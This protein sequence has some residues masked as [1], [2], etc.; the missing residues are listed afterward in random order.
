MKS[1]VEPLEDNKVKVVVD[2]EES[3]LEPALEAAWKEI[4]NEV[5]IPGFRP[6]KAP[7]KLLEKQIDTSYARSE[8]LRTALPEEYTKAVIFHDVDVV[9]PPEL[10]VTAGEEEGDITFSAIVEVRPVITVAGY[11]GLRVELPNPEVSDSDLQEEIDRLRGQYGELEDVERAAG[12]GDYVTVD[13][14]GT[15]DGEALDGLDVE[16]YSYLIGSGMIASEFDENLP[17]ASA[18]DV[19]EFTADHP[20]PEED[21]VEFEITVQVVQE[22]V[23]PELTDEFVSDATEFDTA[24]EFE[25]STRERLVT[26]SEEA[27]RNSVRTRVSNELAKL[28]DEELPD[29]MISAEMQQRLQNMAQQ[30]GASGIGMDDYLQMIGKDPASFS[31]EMR[32]A[33]VEG[34]KVDLALRA[35][36]LAEDLAVTEEELQDQIAEMIGGGGMSIE[37]AMEQLTEAGQLT[38]LRADLASQKALDWLLEQSEFV[39]S[40]GNAVPAELLEAPADEADHDHAD[41]DHADHDHADDDHAGH[42]H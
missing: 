7:R 14:L 10:D 6:G 13:I 41:G 17:G 21:S 23:L 9:A 33:A 27:T 31:E 28:V 34:V 11:N 3:E 12:D 15:R 20:N 25:T 37:Q 1:T 5:R 19:V 38:A 40:E 30:L 22:R 2:L 4:S 32:E 29:S 16:G 8:A 39:D 24:L 36:A 42:D 26:S 35:I 18:G